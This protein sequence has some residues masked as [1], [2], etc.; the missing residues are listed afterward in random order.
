MI[1][2]FNEM[3]DKKRDEGF[4]MKYD[5]GQWDKD[6]EDVAVDNLGIDVAFEVD[7][8]DLVWD[9]LVKNVQGWRDIGASRFALS[10]IENGYRVPFSE[11]PGF[12][13]EK[14]NRSFFE[15]EKWA[16]VEILALKRQIGTHNFGI[17][18]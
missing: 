12:Y 17:T 18:I 2:D 13:E 9:S 16:V 5:M 14:N 1:L 7:T 8:A 3:N 6:V 15:N 10:V 4:L 11:K